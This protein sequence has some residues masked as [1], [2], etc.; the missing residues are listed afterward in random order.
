[1]GLQEEVWPF[2]PYFLKGNWRAK[3]AETR[4]T[5]PPPE[6]HTRTNSRVDPDGEIE[7]HDARVLGTAQHQD[8]RRLWL[9]RRGSLANSW[10]RRRSG[11]GRGGGSGASAKPRHSSVHVRRR[12][13]L[14]SEL[15]GGGNEG[16]GAFTN[17]GK[18][19]FSRRR[20][21]GLS[22]KNRKSPRNEKYSN[23]TQM[24]LCLSRGDK[25]S[26]ELDH[27][28]RFSTDTSRFRCFQMRETS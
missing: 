12:V 19:P 8:V 18:R 11:G 4:L 10:K 16:S 22:E 17:V 6:K 25:V 3:L 5:V 24:F 2:S 27:I 1:M 23:E 21:Q 14:T 13:L 28:R 7:R 15:P 9:R 26:V 20:F